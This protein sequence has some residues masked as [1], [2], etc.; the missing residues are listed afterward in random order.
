MLNVSTVYHDK[1]SELLIRSPLAVLWIL[2]QFSSLSY[3][4]IQKRC[5]C[6]AVA[7]IPG[8]EQVAVI[9]GRDPIFRC[10]GDSFVKVLIVR[11]VV[12]CGHF[13]R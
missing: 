10:P 2:S 6:Q 8:L 12:E 3:V 4:P 5:D 7:R 11:H 1:G 9:A 13:F